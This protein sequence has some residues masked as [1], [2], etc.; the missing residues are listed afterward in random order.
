MKFRKEDRLRKTAEF[1][2]VY[3][4]RKSVADNV[5]IVYGSPN[6]LGRMRLGLSVSRKVGNA[7]IR[8][9]WKRLIR[10]AFRLFILPAEIIVGLDLV[11]IPQKGIAPVPFKDL[12]KSLQKN[13]ERLRRKFAS[14]KKSAVEPSAADL[15]QGE[16]EGV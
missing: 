5:L 15:P 8:N 16:T 11:V 4:D 14:T 1:Q 10:E 3:A 6:G 13:V 12:H 2:R 7:V 9:R